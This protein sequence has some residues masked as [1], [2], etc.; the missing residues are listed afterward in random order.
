M[1]ALVL[2]IKE[3]IAGGPARL[4]WTY[5]FQTC[6]VRHPESVAEHSWYVSF[7]G[8][9]IVR[10]YNNQRDTKKGE[11]LNMVVVL[12]RAVLHDVEEA[13]TGDFPRNF[14][15]SSPDMH[16]LLEKAGREGMRRLVN[17]M[18]SDEPWETTAN[19]LYNSWIDAK[20]PDP[21]GYVIEFADFLAVLGFILQEGQGEG[22]GTIGI[23]V[24]EMSKYY[25][26]FQ[27]EE[28]EFLRP[29]IDQAGQIMQELGI[30]DT[31]VSRPDQST[32]KRS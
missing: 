1:G 6:R 9:A 12:Q 22:N 26:K 15:H 18:V 11:P 17:R 24:A 20:H 23:H 32:T 16:K 21:E 25:G 30:L 19:D 27:R 10:W 3:M 8:L 14:K 5:R 4:R 28:Y 29:L 31:S 13:E 2:N 7:Y